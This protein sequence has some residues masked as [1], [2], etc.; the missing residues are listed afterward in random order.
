M[1]D[2]E[3][4]DDK[5]DDATINSDAK[6]KSITPPQGAGFDHRWVLEEG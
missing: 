2:I 6:K 4:I 1:S 5:R 3:T